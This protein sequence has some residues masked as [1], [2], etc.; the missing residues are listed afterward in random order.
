M[1]RERPHID[2]GSG[3]MGEGYDRVCGLQELL[4]LFLK[5]GMNGLEHG[6]AESPEAA[7][8]ALV[9]PEAAH[10]EDELYPKAPLHAFAD[11]RCDIASAMHDVKGI[12]AMQALG[13]F[14]DMPHIFYR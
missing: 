5:V 1:P 4:F 10:I 8:N 14:P 9:G 11:Q 2:L 7:V 12:L 3:C 6:I 13:H